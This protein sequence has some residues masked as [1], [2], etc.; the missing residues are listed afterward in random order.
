MNIGLFSW[1]RPVAY[2]ASKLVAPLVQIL[3]WTLL[4]TSA[5]G[6]TSASFYVIGNAVQLGIAAGGSMSGMS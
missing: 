6:T 5:T 4:G 3:F 2:L 1:L